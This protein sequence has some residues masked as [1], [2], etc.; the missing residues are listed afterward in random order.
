MLF[1][2]QL[3]IIETN[4]QVKKVIHETF[5]NEG[6]NRVIERIDSGVGVEYW[7]MIVEIRL[8]EAPTV[9]EIL[10]CGREEERL[11]PNYHGFIQRN[12]DGSETETKID[13]N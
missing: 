7:E 9:W 6:R 4:P 11:I 10:R 5:W 2:S 12:D 3:E 8:S 13:I 1:R